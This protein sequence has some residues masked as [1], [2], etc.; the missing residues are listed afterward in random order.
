[1]SYLNNRLGKTINSCTD[2]KTNYIQYTNQGG[3]HYQWGIKSDLLFQEIRQLRV[4]NCSIQ[5]QLLY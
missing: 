2:T 5:P 4:Q 3:L 1:M